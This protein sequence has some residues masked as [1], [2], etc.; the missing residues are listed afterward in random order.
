MRINKVK[1]PTTSSDLRHRAEEFLNEKNTESNPPGTLIEMQRMLHELQVHKIEL[2]MQN[3]ELRQARD[4][5]EVILEKYTNLYDF[6][7]VAY[8][9]LDKDRAIRAANLTCAGLLRI[10]RSRLLGRRFEQLVVPA[11]RPV[12]LAYLGRVAEARVKEFCEVSILKE[13]RHPFSVQIKAVSVESGQ[14]CRLAII[15][16]SE[17]KLIEHNLTRSEHQ[18]AE[19]QM[20]LHLGSWQWNSTTDKV[21]GSD[22]FYRIFGLEF[23]AFDVFLNRVHPDDRDRVNTSVLA[24]LVRQK[25]YKDFFRIMRPDGAIRIVIAQAEAVVDDNGKVTSMTGTAQDVT[26]RRLLEG[27]LETLNCDLSARAADLAVAN[28][29]LEAFSYSV[30][31]DLRRPL[32]TINSCCQALQELYGHQLDEQ[33]TEYIQ[34]MY[35]CTLSMN[36]LIDT[37]LNFSF[38]MRA[39]MCHD[40]VDL[41]VL[42]RKA[43]ENL[44]VQ[45]PA[46]AV[47]FLIADGAVADG[48]TKLLS[49]VLDNIMGNAWKYT[50]KREEAIIEFGVT[51]VDAEQTFF[52]R[53]N[54]SG[55]DMENAEKMFLPFMCLPGSEKLRGHGIGLATV[56]R[57]VRRHGGK[58]WAVGETE[59]GACFYF[60]LAAV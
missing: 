9:T 54:G 47:T 2:E 39:E 52:V 28:I 50:G 21:T 34:G 18:L 44:K 25:S 42:A 57:I 51:E 8:V 53:D 33:F 48:D 40:K 36:G 22:E 59:K 58:V 19:A 4:E 15:D 23:S 1:G 37:L 14:E 49:I 27:K 56:E 6:A 7:P 60:T 41:G 13:G 45:S 11:D 32:T 26:E 46:R 10:S 12:F 30:S 31:H 38:V 24:T 3:A 17:Q 29:E 35:E 5:T 16:I 20:L 43:A 55:F